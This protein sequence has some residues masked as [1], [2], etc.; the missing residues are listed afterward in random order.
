MKISPVIWFLKND[1]VRTSAASA[2]EIGGA[3]GRGNRGP[4]RFTAGAYNQRALLRH[5]RAG[6]L[7]DA[8]GLFFL[9]LRCLAVGPEHDE[10]GQWRR[11]PT[12]DIAGERLLVE[13]VVA[14]KRSCD[15]G[16]DA[17]KSFRCS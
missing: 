14:G 16:E 8:L 12:L 10:P 15:G 6:D 1:G 11:H 7:D 3:P 9:E 13:R 4:G 5:P 17:G 2:P